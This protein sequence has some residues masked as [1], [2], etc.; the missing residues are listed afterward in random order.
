MSQPAA[1][2]RYAVFGHPV[3]HSLSPAMHNAAFAALG[4]RARY[5]ALDVA[6]GELAEQLNAFRNTG[7]GVNLTI[8]LKE[9]GYRLVDAHDASA[10]QLGAVNTVAFV[11]GRTVGHNTDGVGVLRALEEAFGAGPTG[12]RVAV[13]GCGGAGRAVAI[14]C[15][16]A[17]AAAVVL[18]NRTRARAEQV[19][20][21]VAAAAP[22]AG[23]SVASADSEAGLAALHDADLIIQCTSVGLH[24]HDASPLPARVFR[25]GQ[26]VYDLIY[27]QPLTPTLRAARLGGARVANGLGMLLHQGAAAFSIWTGRQPDL[28]AMRRALAAAVAART[29]ET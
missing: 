9:P 22:A 4:W 18:L 28:D 19:A 14:T 8:P 23:V 13:F 3:A 10:R 2:P 27:S 17:G 24:A 6:P 21:E 11:D 26:W 16:A 15:G 5:E 7:G 20:A 1:L 29:Q 25:P 12:R